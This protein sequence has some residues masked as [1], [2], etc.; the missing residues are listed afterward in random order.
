MD[1]TRVKPDEKKS[2]GQPGNTNARSGAD[3]RQAIKRGLTRLAETSGVGSPT[4]REGLDAIADAL[5]GAAAAG[6]LGAIKEIADRTDGKAH[7]SISF[8]EMDETKRLEAEEHLWAICYPE[9]RND[10]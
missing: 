10:D 1:N 5:V 2:G 9:E 4:H 3:F 6:S 8:S 7:Q